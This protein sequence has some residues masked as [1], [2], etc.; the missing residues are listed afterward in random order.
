MDTLKNIPILKHLDAEQLRSFEERCHWVNYG[1][2]E[3]IIDHQEE[4]NDVRF[5][6]SGQVRIVV[7]MLEGREVIFNDFGSGQ[8]F[9]ELSAIDSGSRSANV[10]AL[11][12]TRLCV[13]PQAVF[14]QLCTEVPEVGWE[15]MQHLTKLVRNLSDRLSEFT[16]LKAKHRLYAELL[17]LS[18]T[19]DSNPDQR[20]I[21]PT[22]PQAEIADRISSRREIVSREMK[23]LERKGLLSRERG[24]LILPY[25]DALSKLAAAGWLSSTL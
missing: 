19:R 4:T 5:I 11:T 23:L 9:G 13:M 25:P 10:T 8:F 2:S 14:R 22:P 16:F 3:L 20:I 18:R 15:V 17:R 21:S 7:R 1:A 24:G 6:V 12:P